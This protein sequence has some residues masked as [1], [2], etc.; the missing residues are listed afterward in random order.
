MLSAAGGS[1]EHRGSKDHFIATLDGQIYKWQGFEDAMQ[2]LAIA[3]G[4][5]R[6]GGRS[7]GVW[8]VEVH[9][10]KSSC[11]SSVQVFG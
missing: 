4:L 6:V 2:C 8:W 1:R 10:A 7:W 3:S 5:A 9:I 11:R